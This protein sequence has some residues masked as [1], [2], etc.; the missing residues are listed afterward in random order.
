[1]SNVKA[2]LC[3]LLPESGGL[4]QFRSLAEDHPSD[5][6]WDNLYGVDILRQRV[7]ANCW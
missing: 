1:M 7:C 6:K 2:M 3:K 5:A 4:L